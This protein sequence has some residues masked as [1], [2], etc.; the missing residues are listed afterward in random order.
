MKIALC[1][2]DGFCEV[3][4]IDAVHEGGFDAELLYVW[5]NRM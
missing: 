2:P 4:G 1:W 5:A 3:L